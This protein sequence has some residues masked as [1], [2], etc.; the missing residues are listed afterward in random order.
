MLFGIADTK[1]NCFAVCDVTGGPD[2]KLPIIGESSTVS[3]CLDC[4]YVDFGQITYTVKTI[5]IL[6]NISYRLVKANLIF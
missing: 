1:F 3:F 6:V 5:N 2:Y 4:S